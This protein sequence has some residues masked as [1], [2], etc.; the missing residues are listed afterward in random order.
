MR[1]KKV[2]IIEDNK[3][4]YFLIQ[5]YLSE[6][7]SEDGISRSATLAGGIAGLK[8]NSP[9]VIIL[10]LNLPDS[11]GLDTIRKML[12]HNSE[13]PV[14]VLTG[15]NDLELG[16]TALNLGASDYLSKNQI[17]GESLWKAINYAI[18]RKKNDKIIKENSEFYRVLFQYNQTI[19][20]LIDPENGNILD[21]NNSAMKFYGYT[22]E[23]IKSTKV[24]DLSIGPENEISQ[25]LELALSGK[26]KQSQLHHRLS[27]GE[28]KDVEVSIEPIFINGKKLLYSV[29]VDVTER[30]RAREEIIARNH[31]RLLTNQLLSKLIKLVVG[32]VKLSDL[33]ETAVRDASSVLKIEYVRICFLEGKLCSHNCGHEEGNSSSY[34]CILED[35][36]KTAVEHLSEGNSVIIDDFRE[37]NSTFGIFKDSLLPE[38]VNSMMVVPMMAESKYIGAIVCGSKNKRKWWTEEEAF[39]AS[40]ADLIAIARENEIHS[41]MEVKLNLKIKE[42]KKEVIELNKRLYDLLAVQSVILDGIPDLAWMKD[43]NGKFKAVNKVYSSMCSI[44]KEEIIDKTDFDIWDPESAK[45]YREDDLNVINSRE[46]IKTQEWITGKNGSRRFFETIKVPVFSKDGLVIGTVGI[47]RDITLLKQASEVLEHENRKLEELVTGR[48][49]DLQD[50]ADSLRHEMNERIIVED[51]LMKLSVAVE[52]SPVSIIITDL[53]GI[54]EYVNPKFCDSSGY[55]RQEVVG[56]SIRM[57]RSGKGSKET[58]MQLWEEITAGNVWTG[59]ILNR[60]KNSDLYWEESVVSPIKNSAGLITNFIGITKDITEEKNAKIKLKESEER[61]RAIFENSPLGISISINGVT[62]V[63]NRSFVKMFGYA[64]PS[65]LEGG[66]IFNTIAPSSRTKVVNFLVKMAKDEPVKDNYTYY[67]LKKDG[68]EFP[69]NVSVAEL[70]LPEGRAM[71]GFYVDISDQKQK[72]NQ[73]I[74]SLKEKEVLI[75]E[76]HHRVKNNLQIISSLLN[77]QTDSMTDPVLLEAFNVSRNRVKAMALIHERLYQSK[78]LSLIDFNEYISELIIHLQRNYITDG[79]K[80]DF[81]ISLD[82]IRLSIDTAIPC[83]LIVNELVSNAMKYAFTGKDSGILILSVKKHED[84]FVR[85]EIADNGRGFGPGF[86]IGSVSTLGLQLVQNL[87]DQIGGSMEVEDSSG[88]KFSITFRL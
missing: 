6:F 66:S 46:E 28:I 26:V 84:G 64:D 50:A 12:E 3:A 58:Y 9:D 33:M 62:K 79:K 47:A 60:K 44:P 57:L 43:I 70:H 37:A 87:V 49:K 73:I 22:S 88:V 74:S 55:S 7:T 16:K 36:H 71:V 13:I 14:V 15:N 40:A 24:S 35:L 39:F 31:K 67:G 19:T 17:T 21:A 42:S 80:I 38:D 20:L 48:T 25:M 1:N 69:I 72:E 82:P 51:Q 11:S 78:D 41:T 76:I 85:M 45:A 75:K 23:E 65:E 4:D 18:E 61:F 86:D 77:L 56:K 83:G 29:I 81:D 8:E 32:N 10:D 34:P 54:V 53:K 68:T 52:Q 63:I 27:N 59:E 30:N 5:T 2:L